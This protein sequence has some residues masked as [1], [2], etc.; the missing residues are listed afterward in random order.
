MQI[1]KEIYLN[2]YSETIPPMV[3]AKEGD[4]GRYIRVVILDN[5]AAYT[6]P[7]NVIARIASGDVWNNCT[8][9]NNSILACLTPDMLTSGRHPCQ[10][11]LIQGNTKLTTV[12]FTLEV[13][14]SARNDGAIEGSNDYGVL[15]QA[16]DRAEKAYKD[17][18]KASAEADK[19]A[20]RAQNIADIVT[21]KLDNGELRGPAGTPGKDGAP[22]RTGDTGNPGKDGEPGQPG[23]KGESGIGVLSGSVYQIYTDDADNSAIHCVYEDGLSAPPISYDSATGA[24]KWSY[25]DGQ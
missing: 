1:I 10:I 8:I 11:E 24:L 4:N 9:S 7:A 23:P 17:A 14:K 13:E 16:I 6:I 25:D 20:G 22:G 21:A 3:H 12:S 18:E 15:D 5:A 19:Q 2:F